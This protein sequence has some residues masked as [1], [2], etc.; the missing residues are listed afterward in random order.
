MDLVGM[1]MKSPSA[2]DKLIPGSDKIYPRPRINYPRNFKVRL[3]WNNTWTWMSKYSGRHNSTMGVHESTVKKWPGVSDNLSQASDKIIRDSRTKLSETP[4]Q[5]IREIAS[6]S[7]SKPT[8]DMDVRGLQATEKD[9][10]VRG[11]WMY[12][13]PIMHLHEV[14]REFLFVLLFLFGLLKAIG[15]VWLLGVSKFFTWG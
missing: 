15:V 12:S 3:G 14:V 10:I 13:S 7:Q 2:S 5:N 9:K 1:Y 11:Y 6:T 4:G 8:V